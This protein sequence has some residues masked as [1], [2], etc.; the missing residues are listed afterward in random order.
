MSVPYQNALAERDPQQV[1]AETPARLAWIYDALTT[2]QAEAHPAPG[3]WN[4]RERM[5]H[6][7]D[8]ESALA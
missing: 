8:C 1:I 6:L 5:C 2:E 3:K 7:S 4:L